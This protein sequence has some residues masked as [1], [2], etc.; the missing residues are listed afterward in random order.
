MKYRFFTIPVQASDAAATALNQFLAEQRIL[1]VER[2]FIADGSNSAWAFCIGYDET[3]HNLLAAKTGK[4]DYKKVLSAEDFA[5]FA[6]LRM[7]RK[8]LAEQEGVPAYALFTNQ[9]LA[10][11]VVNRVNTLAALRALSGVGEGRVEKYGRAFIELLINA[12]PAPSTPAV[13]DN[14]T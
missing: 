3:E 1:A 13:K 9:Q 2:E 11:M 5:V 12:W 14:E 10:D 7:L 8:Q 6:K 4:V